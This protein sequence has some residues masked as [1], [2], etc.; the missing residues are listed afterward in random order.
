M[1]KLALPKGAM[2]LWMGKA[3]ELGGNGNG[4]AFG[5]LSAL[6][7]KVRTGRLVFVFVCALDDHFLDRMHGRPIVVRVVSGV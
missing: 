3:R 7:V 6:L 2:W 1:T 4:D 5:P